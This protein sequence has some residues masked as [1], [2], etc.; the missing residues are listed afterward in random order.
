MSQIL[1]IE[2]NVSVKIKI[3]IKVFVAEKPFIGEFFIFVRE[4]SRKRKVTKCHKQIRHFSTNIRLT[5]KSTGT[6]RKQT[7]TF[8][9]TP[10]YR[11]HLR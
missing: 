2:I 10:I 5:A 6:A 7:G 4:N 8:L 11:T 9:R 1:S 3:E